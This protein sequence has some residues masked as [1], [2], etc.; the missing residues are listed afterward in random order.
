MEQ[1]A[2]NSFRVQQA[3]Y[4]CHRLFKERVRRQRAILPTLGHALVT[5]YA[6]EAQGSPHPAWRKTK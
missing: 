1:D 2:R 5:A 3:P 6:D 4:W